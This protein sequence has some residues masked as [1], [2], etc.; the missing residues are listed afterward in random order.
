MLTKKI[1][2]YRGHV[3]KKVFIEVVLDTFKDFW[4]LRW[5]QNMEWPLKR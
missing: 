3:K 4:M 1:K 2:T 5:V